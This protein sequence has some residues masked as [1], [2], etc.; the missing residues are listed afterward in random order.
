MGAKIDFYKIS[1][2]FLLPNLWPEHKTH[3]IWAF[4]PS[5]HHRWRKGEQT[6]APA[7]KYAP[8]GVQQSTD[9]SPIALEASW[10]E[11]CFPLLPAAQVATCFLPVAFSDAVLAQQVGPLVQEVTGNQEHEKKATT[12]QYNHRI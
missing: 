3:L 11:R 12:G 4:V 2:I 10:W 7:V 5:S 8:L 9:G 1:R 6:M